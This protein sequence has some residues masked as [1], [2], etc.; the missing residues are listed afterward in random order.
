[1]KDGRPSSIKDEG[2]EKAE[3]AL[4]EQLDALSKLVLEPLLPHV[5]TSKR[6]LVSPDGNLWLLPWEALDADGRPLRR[7]EAQHQL[8]DQRPRPAARGRRQGEGERSAG[9]GRP[10]LRPRPGKAQPRRSVCWASAGRGGARARCR[11]RCAWARCGGC[12]ARRR[13]RRAITPS[14]KNY[15]GDAPRVYT[16]EQALEAVFKAVRSPRVLVLCT[17]GFFLPDQEVAA[18]RAGRRGQAEGR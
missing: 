6:W 4:R 12:R 1:M 13:R 5:G 2:E 7:R 11:A 3:K 8:P 16:R 14:L 18:R 15:A 17:H 9:A 10:R